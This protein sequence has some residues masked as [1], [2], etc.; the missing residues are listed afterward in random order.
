MFNEVGYELK[1][2][3]LNLV[4]NFLKGCWK[5]WDGV[6]GLISGRKMK[7]EDKR[8]LRVD[9]GRIGWE[10][11]RRPRISDF[12]ILQVAH[13]EVSQ[14][15]FSG[16]RYFAVQRQCMAQLTF[17]TCYQTRE[18]ANPAGSRVDNVSA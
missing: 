14:T 11:G 1:N 15:G 4:I 7:K 18:D 13:L 12:S 5:G 3:D 8:K 2:L 6:K 17:L 10:Q 9:G 16:L